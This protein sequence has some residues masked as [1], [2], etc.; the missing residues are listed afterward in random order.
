MF[1]NRL[2]SFLLSGAITLLLCISAVA[3]DQTTR[4]ARDDPATQY[5]SVVLDGE[6][7][8]SLDFTIT[9]LGSVTI[10][11]LQKAPTGA[12]GE[13]RGISG[14]KVRLR[15]RD[16]GYEKWHLDQLTDVEGVYTFECLRPGNYVIELDPA[17]LTGIVPGP[18]FV[19]P[20]SK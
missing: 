20:G 14:F 7:K 3:Q 1:K 8:L 16:R 10:Q 6:Q 18:A 13:P 12:A 15:S 4:D 2:T 19:S 9:A 11:V 5:K 17:D